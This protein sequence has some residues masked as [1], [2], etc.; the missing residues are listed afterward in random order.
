[1]VEACSFS[2]EVEHLYLHAIRRQG[3][4]RGSAIGR[5]RPGSCAL[6]RK[7]MSI[8]PQLGAAAAS[9]RLQLPAGNQVGV[10]T[11]WDRKKCGSSSMDQI[12]LSE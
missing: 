10:Q 11:C 7:L 12:S 8:R 5:V 9:V 2:Q 3:A 6:L 1:M 4:D